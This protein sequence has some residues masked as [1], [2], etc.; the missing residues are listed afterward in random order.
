MSPKYPKLQEM[1]RVRSVEGKRGIEKVESAVLRRGMGGDKNMM[2]A[3]QQAKPQE[4]KH[5]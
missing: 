5:I 1:M 3:C 4:Y 2:K